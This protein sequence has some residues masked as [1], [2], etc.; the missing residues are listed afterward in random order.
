MI[1]ITLEICYKLLSGGFALKKLSPS[2]QAIA[3][4][5]ISRIKDY[6]LL[7]KIDLAPGLEG[8]RSVFVAL[9][10]VLLPKIER[11]KESSLL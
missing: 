5:S 6:E 1:E 7:M 4:Y 9:A 2:I 3:F 10:I 8:A 11:F